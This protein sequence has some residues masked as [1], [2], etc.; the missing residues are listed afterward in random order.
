MGLYHTK[1][2]SIFI[3]TCRIFPSATEEIF[4]SDLMTLTSVLTPTH[5]ELDSPDKNQVWT[6]TET[7]RT[8]QTVSEVEAAPAPADPAAVS[9]RKAPGALQDCRDHRD[10]GVSRDIRGLKVC[11]ARRE[12]RECLESK[13]PEGPKETVGRWGCPGS[14]V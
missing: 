2:L 7:V 10:L 4:H 13:V 14:Q 3:C 1:I 6:R 5:T 8:R 9:Q 12:T 11:L